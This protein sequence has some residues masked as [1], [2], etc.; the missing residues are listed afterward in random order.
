MS[1]YLHP[2]IYAPNIDIGADSCFPLAR[3]SGNVA[4]ENSCLSFSSSLKSRKYWFLRSIVI[5]SSYGCIRK[6][7]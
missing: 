3:S 6:R 1:L 5:L 7:K 2:S 4:S